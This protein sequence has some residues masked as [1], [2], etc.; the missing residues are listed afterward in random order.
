MRKRRLEQNATEADVEVRFAGI[1]YGGSPEHKAHPHLFRLTSSG[2]PP[3][4]A[5]LCDRDAGFAP[6]DVDRIEGLLDRAK[7]AR[8]IGNLIW[9]VDDNGWVYELQMTNAS[10]NEHHGYP[11]RATDPF[12]ERVYRFFEAW[13]S[14]QGTIADRD[15]A[16]ACR[17]RYGLSP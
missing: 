6:A 9:T 8:L 5:T 2:F 14:K 12:V 17:K 11:L 15:A 7:H 10:R 1:T 4:D 16:A 3:P 13:A